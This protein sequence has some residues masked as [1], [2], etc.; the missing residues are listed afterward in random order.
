GINEQQ[1]FSNSINGEVIQSI[2][3]EGVQIIRS[4]NSSRARNICAPA[5]VCSANATLVGN[6]PT[7]LV[8][9]ASVTLVGGASVTLIGDVLAA[10][11]DSAFT[12]APPTL[13][14]N[15]PDTSVGPSLNFPAAPTSFPFTLANN[16]HDTWADGTLTTSV[17]DALNTSIG[18]ALTTSIGGNNPN[19]QLLAP[20][21]LLQFRAM[22]SSGPQHQ[23][24]AIVASQRNFQGLTSVPT[25]ALNQE[26]QQWSCWEE[27]NGQQHWNSQRET[28]IAEEIR[29]TEFHGH[30]MIPFP[31]QT[32]TSS[33]AV[34]S[35]LLQNYQHANSSYPPPI[36]PD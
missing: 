13:V 23:E 17:G 21:D 26:Y 15:T 36:E 33:D 11:T 9:D 34:N 5:T 20:L 3:F 19:N 29:F 30:N 14:N 24:I 32:V 16:V 22:R 27:R 28:D 7:T 4:L 2:R 35:N 10:S 25:S 1:Y 8:N 12:T 31:F 18:G 6:V